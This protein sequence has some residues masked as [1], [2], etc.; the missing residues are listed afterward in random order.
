MDRGIDG[1]GDAVIGGAGAGDS[2]GDGA[3]DPPPAPGRQRRRVLRDA[4]LFAT[5][6]AAGMIGLGQVA[7]I[8]DRKLPILGG[9]ASATIKTRKA[10][11]GIGQL[12]VTWAVP[13]DKRVV[14]LTFDDGPQPNWTT[15]VLDTL[16]RYAVPATFF[17]VGHRVRKYAG[18]VQG[19]MDAHEVGN[20]TYDHLDLARRDDTQVYDDLSRTHDAIADVLNTPPNLFRP[21]YGHL[22]GSTALASARLGYEMVLWSLQMLESEYLGNPIGHANAIAS[23]VAPGT[24]LLAH[25]IGDPVRLVT[26]DGLPRLIELLLDRGYEFVTVSDLMALRSSASPQV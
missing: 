18:V 22:G 14:A 2:A 26:I 21:P 23:A 9:P 5:G 1:G 11:P 20:H 17:M 12:L 10:H 3:G 7:R 8:A 6:A 13:T 16:D 15:R 4:A 25:D 19:R 24:I